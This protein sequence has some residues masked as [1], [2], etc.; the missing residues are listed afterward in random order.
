V[1]VE[2]GMGLSMAIDQSKASILGR[3]GGKDLQWK[4]IMAR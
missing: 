1:V 4:V 2:D 3:H